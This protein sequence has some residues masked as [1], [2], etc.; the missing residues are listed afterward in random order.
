MV[1]TPSVDDDE[2]FVCDPTAL[3][4]FY[5]SPFTLAAFEEDAGQTN[6]STVRAE[7]NGLF[8]VQR[9]DAAA[10]FFAAPSQQ[11]PAGPLSLSREARR[12]ARI[13][14]VHPAAR[15]AVGD[16][17]QVLSGSRSPEPSPAH[18]P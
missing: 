17:D 6:S 2:G 11:D 10:T 15:R 1:V 3:G 18:D 9:P 14:G 13:G 5:A 7:A 12:A 16:R 8:I 4:T